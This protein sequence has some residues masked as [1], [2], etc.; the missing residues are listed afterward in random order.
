MSVL[1]QANL[2]GQQRIDVPHIRAIESSICADFDL[3]AGKVMAGF[4]AMVVSGFT[5]ITTGAIGASAT[6]LQIVTAG[7]I[8]LHPLATE[9]G[10]I[11]SVP[12]NR[13]V[14]IL[15][16]A[17]ARL[18]GS[19]TANA[20][21]F[22]GI[23][24]RRTPDGTT[25][26]L[27]Q[28]LD[29]NTD[30]ETPKS[31][32]LGRTLDYVILV[33]TQDFTTTP[34]VAPI[35]KVVTD[36]NNLVTSITD[37]RQMMFRLGSG[38]SIPDIFS[39]YSWPGGR[40][41]STSDNTFGD[42]DKVI[43]SMKDWVDA[44]MTRTWEL[45]GGEHWYS[46]TADRN[47]K[48]V[49]TGATFTDGEWFEYVSSNLHW[50]GLKFVF[51]NCTAF[52]NDVKDQTVD[53]TGLTD[54]ADGD[55]IY[56]D[57]DRTTNRTGVTALQAV[58]APY[59]TLGTPAVPGT[60][61]IIAWRVG[62][63]IFTKDSPFPVGATFTPA[64]NTSLGI[65]QLTIPAANP[66]IPLVIPV[67]ANGSLTTQSTVS[68]TYGIQG[69]GNGLGTGV[70]GRGGATGGA[71]G[72]QGYG[73]GNGHGV[74]GTGGGGFG[75]G[76]YGTNPGGTGAGVEGSGSGTN[77]GVKGSG[78]S[79]SGAGGRFLGGTPGTS[80]GGPA[81]V[82]LEDPVHTN[83]A[84]QWL[85]Y[86]ASGANVKGRVDHVGYD[87]YWGQHVVYENWMFPAVLTATQAPVTQSP[88]WNFY[89]SG[90]SV[91][92]GAAHSSSSYIPVYEGPGPWMQFANFSGSTG[93]FISC[94]PIN[95]SVD[96]S[97][98]ME[99]N[100]YQADGNSAIGL[101]DTSNLA[102][103]GGALN[104]AT[105]PLA[106]NAIWFLFAGSV[107]SANWQVVNG[108][109]ES[110][111]FLHDYLGDALFRLEYHGSGSPYGAQTAIFYAMNNL[112]AILH[113]QIV[114]SGLPPENTL[115]YVTIMSGTLGAGPGATLA[116]GPVRYQYN[117]WIDGPTLV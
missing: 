92:T 90:G 66:S 35:A 8:L 91:S 72:M 51:E 49:R 2:L 5:V 103:I 82:T 21:N 85:R 46:S 12:S 4:N 110:H 43:S 71:W 99:W 14:E 83:T 24:L 25:S 81:L 112:G 61:F 48:M 19:F 32:P 33:S 3:L 30:T 16:S 17:N 44:V 36:S 20:T 29:P 45:G 68:G 11:F 108:G 39:S 42:G 27:V 28:F 26:D 52:Y 94:M 102:N 7:S 97:F 58:K 10:T 57:L 76:V 22:V 77:D 84:P 62:S 67:D 64:T 34:G 55:C 117:H 13:A 38:G 47:V 78:G 109:V 115:M 111:G 80:A 88:K 87:S 59:L 70:V 73:T 104:I 31:V 74:V 105:P 95:L 114:T 93:S 96:I 37:A 98:V 56:V 107:G 54:L 116:L 15:N 63:T 86:D 40:S 50:Q 9:S 65:V 89:G 41:E 18:S 6:A 106:S 75:A 23:D 113:S 1:R 100:A 69:T 53:L 79:G 101:Q 60:R